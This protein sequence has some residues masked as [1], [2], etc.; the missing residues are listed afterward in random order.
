MNL[1]RV[2]EAEAA[3]LERFPGGFADPGMEPIRKRHNVD[4]LTAYAKE[5]MNAVTLGQPDRFADALVH[6]VTRASM[7]S[8]FEKAPFRDCIASLDSKEKA[9]LAGAFEKR[10]VGRNRKQGFE[11]IVGFLARYKLARWSLVSALPF[12]LAPTRDVFVKPTT[13]KKI[14]AELE[15]EGL[16]YRPRPDWSFYDGFRRVIR[17][18]GRELDPS[19]TRNNAAITGLLVFSL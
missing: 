8:R 9:A 15:V 14:V 10:L 17:D 12:Y 18:V 11:E 5:N 2:R 4:R 19:L 13:A 1:R 3:F 6:I 7:V 16:V